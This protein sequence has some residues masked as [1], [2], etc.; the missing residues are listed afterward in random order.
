MRKDISEIGKQ[1]KVGFGGIS[2]TECRGK[3]EYN[4]VE[5]PWTWTTN[6]VVIAWEGV[7]GGKGR[8]RRDT[9]W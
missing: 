4:L 3:K 9:W 8:Y 6:S 2:N 7:E 5:R 1:K